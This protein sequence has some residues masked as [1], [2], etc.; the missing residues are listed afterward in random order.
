LYRPSNPL[1]I[2]S[3]ILFKKPNILNPLAL[4]YIKLYT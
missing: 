2:C 1:D 4:I 3:P